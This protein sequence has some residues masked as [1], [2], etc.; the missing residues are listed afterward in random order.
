MIYLTFSDIEK[1]YKKDKFF[2]HC[3]KE[4]DLNS[5]LPNFRYP[6]ID[7]YSTIRN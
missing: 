3:S 2:Y 5:E 4:D 7:G 6:F 1:I